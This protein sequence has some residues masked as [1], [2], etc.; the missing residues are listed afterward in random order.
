MS[1]KLWPLDGLIQQTKK[2][3][4]E[5]VLGTGTYVKAEYY[6]TVYNINIKRFLLK[7]GARS[8]FY[9]IYI[10]TA[11]SS[12]LVWQFFTASRRNVNLWVVT[13]TIN[14]P[15]SALS[16]FGSVHLDPCPYPFTHPLTVVCT[17]V[18]PSSHVY[19]LPPPR[20]S[21]LPPQARSYLH[22]LCMLFSLWDP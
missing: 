8:Y 18:L 19:P 20:A 2:S 6:Y 21:L 10:Y 3:P 1:F 14:S 12:N 16:T 5:N 13:K 4:F 22:A 7:A 9:A 11:V 17:R 15:I